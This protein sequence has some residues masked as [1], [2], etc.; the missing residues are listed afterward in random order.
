MANKLTKEQTQ[1][2]L[3]KVAEVLEEAMAEYEMLEKMDLE[4]AEDPSR[5]FPAAAASDEDAPEE[6]EE[7]DK[8]KD[9]E[10]EED[11]KD[12]DSDEDKEEEMSDDAMK[13]EFAA[14][15]SKMEKRGLIKKE[16]AKTEEVKKSENTQ[17]ETLQKSIDDRFES[18]TKTISELSETV[19][20]IASAPA[21]RKGVAGY[22]PLKKNDEGS[23]E[24]PLNKAEVVNKLLDLKKSGK[25]IPTDLFMRIETGRHTD[26]DL[27]FI[28]G[29][30]G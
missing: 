4:L 25:T 1:E 9:E 19:K 12:E 11:D 30:L 10:D 29:I 23:E 15:Q 17:G 18:L 28:K 26:T 2:A 21:P 7:D 24:Q 16:D 3:K 13:S 6:D 22:Q 5:P 8:D 20:K 14:L 27:K